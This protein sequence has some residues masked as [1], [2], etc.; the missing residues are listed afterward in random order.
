MSTKSVSVPFDDLMEHIERYLVDAHYIEPTDFLIY[1]DLG[2][3]VTDDGT[4]NI[5]IETQDMLDYQPTEMRDNH[6]NNIVPLRG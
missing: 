6:I 3:D 2:I 1:A 5:D 4:V